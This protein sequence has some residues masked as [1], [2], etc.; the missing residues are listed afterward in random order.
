MI[1][2]FVLIAPSQQSAGQPISYI[3]ICGIAVRI[4]GVLECW[5][6]N[7]QLLLGSIAD[8]KSRY[9]AWLEGS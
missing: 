2:L 5:V 3:Y 9:L 7:A 6:I 4:P 1:L 8:P